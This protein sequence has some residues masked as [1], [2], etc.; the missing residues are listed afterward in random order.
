[1][2]AEDLEYRKLLIST[3][4]KLNDSYDKLVVTL[5]GGALALSIAFLKDIVVLDEA[6]F[7][8]IL[9]LSWS[10]FIISLAFIFG[11]ILFGI[12]AY[13][14][15]VN[16]LDEDTIR[17]EKIG[18]LFSTLTKWFNRAAAIALLLGLLFITT[19]I[20][21]NIGENHESKA[22]KN[23]SEATQSTAK[24]LSTDPA[25]SSKTNPKH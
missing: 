21:L 25:P 19:F 22:T 15:A 4:H 11:E 2:D 18:G 20:F 5:S 3:Q 14:K 8:W 7:T 17:K 23:P 1:M 13:K 9:A 12:E 6:R 16:Q 24:T 10:L